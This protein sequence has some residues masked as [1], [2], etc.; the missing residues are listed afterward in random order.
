[1]ELEAPIGDGGRERV[2]LEVPTGGGGGRAALADS[3]GMHDFRLCMI[4]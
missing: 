2:A 3:E 4:T 1:M